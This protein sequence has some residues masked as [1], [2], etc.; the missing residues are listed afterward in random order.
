[1]KIQYFILMY[2]LVSSS[3]LLKVLISTFVNTSASE[4]FCARSKNISVWLNIEI[5]SV[6]TE[7]R[8]C[9]SKNINWE[10]VSTDL[11]SDPF[12]TAKI[13]WSSIMRALTGR[14]N[15]SIVFLFWTNSVVGVLLSTSSSNQAFTCDTSFCNTVCSSAVKNRCNKSRTVQ[16]N[17]CETLKAITWK[18]SK[19]TVPW[20]H[21][22]WVCR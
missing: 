11:S 8:S 4:R 3:N 10:N 6:T 20:I 5:N 14:N 2:T 21:P 22:E 12:Q 9:K 1:M 18:T 17:Y 15:S 16:R 7:G 19:R 13:T